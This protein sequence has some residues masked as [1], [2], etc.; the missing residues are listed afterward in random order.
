MN[1]HTRPTIGVIEGFFG[2]SWSMSEREQIAPFLQQSGYDFYI[3]AP[4][5]DPFL[6]RT[7][8]QH[9]PATQLQR[10]H[11]L[12]N[13]YRQHQLRFGIGLSPLDICINYTVAS[14]QAFINKVRTLNTLTP[15]VL[16]LLFDDMRGD[17]PDLAATQTRLCHLA[18]EHTTA[19]QIILCPTYY[20]DDP[21]LEH[22]FGAKPQN[23]WQT[24]GQQLDPS[25]AL[26]WT[27]P[28]VCSET[29]PTEHL[30]QVT[31]KLNRKPFLWDNYPVNDGAQKSQ[32]L[33]LRPFGTDRASLAPF[34]AGHAVNPMNQALLSRLALASLP[35]AY[36]QGANYNPEQLLPILLNAQCPEPLAQ[37]L[38]LDLPLLQ[39]TGL[40][41]MS[42]TDK[43][44]LTNRY[45]AFAQ[46]SQVACEV[47]DWL[48]DQYA[49]DPA[50]LTD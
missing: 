8:Q 9:W 25:V 6:R 35:L 19:Q 39:E 20:S 47:T 41:A 33:H 7:W 36:T 49:F 48:T 44:H 26:F 14:E 38:L 22:V 50:C 37:A 18:A 42:A 2:R 30:I 46:S 15:D 4:K 13:H 32:H 34:I 31:E 24:L 27:G 21:L 10:L 17:L 11:D 5:S 16:C 23:Y 3:Y 28:K 40:T 43:Q 45:R 29:F 12:R 1:N